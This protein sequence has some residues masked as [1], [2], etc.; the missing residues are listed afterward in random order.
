[1]AFENQPVTELRVPDNAGVDASG[2]VNPG[3]VVTTTIPAEL[4]SW[5]G[6]T[7]AAAQ[8][9]YGADPDVYWFD[10]VFST[11]RIHGYVYQNAEIRELYREPLSSPPTDTGVFTVPPLARFQS[12]VTLDSWLDVAGNLNARGVVYS[13]AYSGTT[14]ASGFLTVTHGAPWTP[15]GGWFITTNPAGSFAQAWGIDNIG[16]TT[17]RL[18]F[19]ATNAATGPLVSTAVS[20]R[21]FLIK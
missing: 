5:Y 21:L 3:L 10:L 15:I 11:I 4:V 18:R 2:A 13:V 6:V 12:G 20:G 7:P 9:Y 19:T 8:F 16:V 14:D 1:M 17:C